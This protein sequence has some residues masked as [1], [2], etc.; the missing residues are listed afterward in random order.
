MAPRSRLVKSCVLSFWSRITSPQFY[1]VFITY[2]YT[3][4]TRQVGI[5]ASNVQIVKLK[6]DKDRKKILD[7]RDKAKLEAMAKAKG[8]YEEEAMEAA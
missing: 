4:L 8:K 1:H 5:H 6:M 3:T 7:R 2:S